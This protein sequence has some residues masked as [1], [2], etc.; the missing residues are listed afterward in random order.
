MLGSK[1]V[2]SCNQMKGGLDNLAEKAALSIQRN[3]EM[4]GFDSV[5]F[6]SAEA[7]DEFTGFGQVGLRSGSE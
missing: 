5:G 4:A 7:P 3:V 2:S 1:L 6:R